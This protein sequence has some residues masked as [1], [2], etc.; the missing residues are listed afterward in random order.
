MLGLDRAII[1]IKTCNNIDVVDYDYDIRLLLN[2][3]ET[4]NGRLYPN[5]DSLAKIID[6]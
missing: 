1:S 4:K 5:D 3:K 6:I 2:L